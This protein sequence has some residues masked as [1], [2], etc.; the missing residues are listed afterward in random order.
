MAKQHKATMTNFDVEMGVP[1]LRELIAATTD[2]AVMVRLIA[3]ARTL[4]ALNTPRQEQHIEILKKYAAV[5]EDGAEFARAED[6]DLL[7]H[8]EAARPAAVAEIAELRALEVEWQHYKVSAAE[9]GAL[10]PLPPDTLDALR[11]MIEI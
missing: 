5:T 1:A 7:W 4:A 2:N 10:P 3:N 6:G 11:F 9:L 8:D